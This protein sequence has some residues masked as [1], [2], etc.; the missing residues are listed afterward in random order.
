M[1]NQNIQK[2][3]FMVESF[4]TIGSFDYGCTL[5]VE[6]FLTL[7][8]IKLLQQRLETMLCFVPLSKS[9]IHKKIQN[10]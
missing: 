4:V 3:M 5:I 6:I 1:K 8:I 9:I 10:G 7:F 2:G